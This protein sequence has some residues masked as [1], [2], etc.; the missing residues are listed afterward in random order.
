M[1]LLEKLVISLSLGFCKICLKCWNLWL[2]TERKQVLFLQPKKFWCTNCHGILSTNVTVPTKYMWLSM[3]KRRLRQR[4]V[5]CVE[6]VSIKSENHGTLAKKA[7]NFC[8]FPIED[9]NI[10]N[11]FYKIQNLNL[12]KKI[13]VVPLLRRIQK[14]LSPYVI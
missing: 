6:S 8:C 9:I 4:N 13:S 11:I 10:S 5:K 14:A 2:G 3:W 1:R 7:S 12:W